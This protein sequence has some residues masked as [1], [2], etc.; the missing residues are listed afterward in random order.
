MSLFFF[1]GRRIIFLFLIFIPSIH[2]A[3]ENG[4]RIEERYCTQSDSQ[5]DVEYIDLRGSNCY[6]R[7]MKHIKQVFV[8]SLH[9]A[10]SRSQTHS[11]SSWFP[12]E[13]RRT[14]GPF[15]LSLSFSLDYPRP[16]PQNPKKM[17]RD[18]YTQS[19]RTS[20]Q[21]KRRWWTG[22]SNLTWPRQRGS[23]SVSDTHG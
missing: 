15:S 22:T 10:R 17:N 7:W 16:K 6:R 4:C 5:I 8:F 1:W 18:I 3:K 21:R 12:R 20:G 11:S 9:R 2:P 14:A 23:F 19:T 13:R